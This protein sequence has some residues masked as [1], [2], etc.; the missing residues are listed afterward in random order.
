[1]LTVEGYGTTG[2][3]GAGDEIGADIADGIDSA[4]P[5]GVVDAP[6][7]GGA[8]IPGG[9][10]ATASGSSIS[11]SGKS[12]SCSSNGETDMPLGKVEFIVGG[13]AGE[14]AGAGGA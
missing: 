2:V 14:I 6:A 11:S 13:E 9:G 5:A 1:V 10:A 7:A 3:A 8:V 4:S 12:G